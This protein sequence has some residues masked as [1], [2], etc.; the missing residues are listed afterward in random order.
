MRHSCCDGG[1]DHCK[2]EAEEGVADGFDNVTLGCPGSS[3]ATTLE[4]MVV[5]SIVDIDF[6]LGI[7]GLD[8]APSNLTAFE[9]E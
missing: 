7:F 1:F 5:A 4:H 3:G 9:N 6:P 2:L 8:P